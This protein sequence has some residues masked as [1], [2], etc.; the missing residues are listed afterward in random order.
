AVAEA[1]GGAGP[2]GAAAPPG[3]PAAGEPG[4]P[5]RPGDGPGTARGSGRGAGPAGGPWAGGTPPLAGPCTPAG[6]WAPLAERGRQVPPGKR[7]LQPG[8]KGP[9]KHLIPVSPFAARLESRLQPVGAAECRLKPGLQLDT[10][11][12]IDN[13]GREGQPWRRRRT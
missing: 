10:F 4:E 6:G 7:H 3:V 9:P 12:R 11:R 2:A 8:R 13:A 1:A 5:A